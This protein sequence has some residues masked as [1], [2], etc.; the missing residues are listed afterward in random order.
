M[1]KIV[2][3]ICVFALAASGLMAQTVTPP[4]Q[5]VETTGMVGLAQGQYA[6]FNVLN[7][8]VLPPA[9]GIVC[10]ALLTFLDANGTVLKTKLVNVAAG[11]SSFIDLFS[12]LDLQLAADTRREI[13]A[14]YTTPP[15]VPATTTTPAT[16]PCKL[17]TT[18]EIIDELSQ[19]TQAVLGGIHTVPEAPAT[20]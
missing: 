13:R 2:Q 17:I 14:T 10:S 1:L 8:G 9:T 20:N 5:D 4:P 19:R 7:P 12:D 3:G 15:V 18:L 6:H 16:T 11:T